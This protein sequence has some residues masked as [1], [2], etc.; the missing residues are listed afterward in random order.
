MP[1]D[2]GSKRAQPVSPELVQVLAVAGGVFRGLQ[3]IPAG[4]EDVGP[5]K[6]GQEWETGLLAARL[7]HALS[8][9]TA[10]RPRSSFDL[11]TDL[12]ALGRGGMILGWRAEHLVA[13]FADLNIDPGVDCRLDDLICDLVSRQ[14]AIRKGS[15]NRLAQRRPMRGV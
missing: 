4:A 2:A 14:S 11:E 15:S 7:P 13:G 9:R 10:A 8:G 1:G 6:A 12:L 5:F 3:H